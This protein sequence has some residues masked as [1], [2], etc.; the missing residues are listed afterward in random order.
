MKYPNSNVFFIQLIVLFY[1][2]TERVL[3]IAQGIKVKFKIQLVLS[4]P[5]TSKTGLDFFEKIL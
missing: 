4:R 5:E 2:S 3:I 1:Q